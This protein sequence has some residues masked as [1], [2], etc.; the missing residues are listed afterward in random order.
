MLKEIQEILTTNPLTAP[1]LH[2]HPDALPRTYLLE[3]GAEKHAVTFDRETY[4]LNPEIRFMTY[5]EPLFDELLSWAT[6]Q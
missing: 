6:G 4:D 1:F 3:L 2:E 5:G